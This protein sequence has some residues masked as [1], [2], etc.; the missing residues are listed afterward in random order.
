MVGIIKASE[1]HSV[2]IYLF[3]VE[4]SKRRFS[5]K[6]EVTKQSG[7]KRYNFYRVGKDIDIAV[8]DQVWQEIKQ[9][10]KSTLS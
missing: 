6:C 4:A 5:V 7:E 2:K 10:I 8:D 1:V 3:E 9:A